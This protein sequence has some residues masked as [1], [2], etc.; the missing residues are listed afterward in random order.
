MRPSFEESVNMDLQEVFDGN[1]YP[2]K[3]S[4]VVRLSHSSALSKHLWFQ[5]FKIVTSYNHYVILLK[6]T[7]KVA[8]SSSPRKT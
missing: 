1:H 6:V 7:I 3:R 4:H 8:G 5:G 2:R